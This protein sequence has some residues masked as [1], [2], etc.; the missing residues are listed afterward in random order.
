MEIGI[1]IVDPD[2]EITI[3]MS[4]R[5]TDPELALLRI[6]SIVG[7]SRHCSITDLKLTI[8]NN[9]ITYDDLK[10]LGLLMK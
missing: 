9:P 7:D 4:Y 3:G 10:I 2:T 1:Q 8:D 6:A 5:Y